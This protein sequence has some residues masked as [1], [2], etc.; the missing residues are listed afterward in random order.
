MALFL[1]TIVNKIDRK[2][3]VSVPAPFRDAL[4]GQ[5]FKGVV[6]LRSFRHP[7]IQCGSMSWMEQVS[8]GVNDLDLFSQ[9]H[10]DL[11]AALFAGAQALA[12]DGDGRIV[13]PGALMEHANL[14]EQAAF[15]G[16]GHQFEV[17]QPEAFEE[18]QAAARARVS[19]RGLTVKQ[20]PDGGATA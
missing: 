6:A 12:F 15:V 8:A 3:R 4:S 5:S 1:G 14:T 9:E 11:T 13:L 20:R 17:W 18:L 10:D 7:A 19:E 2:G 16:R